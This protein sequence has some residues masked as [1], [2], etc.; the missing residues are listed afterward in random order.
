MR[1]V[2]AISCRSVHIYHLNSQV[3]N[4]FILSTVWE[5]I[6]KKYIIFVIKKKLAVKKAKKSKQQQKKSKQ[7]NK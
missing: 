4:S 3:E 1:S 7:T 2:F 5:T 6:T